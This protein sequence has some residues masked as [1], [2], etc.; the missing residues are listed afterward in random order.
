VL[1]DVLVVVSEL[2]TNAVM[3]SG[4]APQETITLEATIDGARVRISVHEPD[5][6]AQ[7][8][9]LGLRVV[10]TLAHRWGVDRPDGRVVWAELASL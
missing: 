6:F 8:G 2:V 1:D 10:D 9:G 5:A 4:C 3:H 7:R